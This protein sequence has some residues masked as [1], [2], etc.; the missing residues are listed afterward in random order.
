MDKKTEEI[1]IKFGKGLAKPFTGKNGREY[2]RIQIPNEDSGDHS[3][4]AS[5]VLPAKAVHDN[6]YGKG[7]WAKIPAEGTTTV[8]KSVLTEGKDGKRIWENERTL[9]PNRELKARVEAYKHRN[10][11]SALDQLGQMTKKAGE[12][13]PDPAK[14]KGKNA[15]IEK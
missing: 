8:T 4:W 1:S 2:L 7:L 13:R 6:Q 15:G 14:A 9:V 5:F 11:E 12:Q 10:R 3:P